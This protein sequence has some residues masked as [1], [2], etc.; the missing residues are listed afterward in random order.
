MRYIHYI[1]S[2]MMVALMS[3][4]AGKKQGASKHVSDV[5]STIVFEEAKVISV[6][7]DDDKVTKL[8]IHNPLRQQ[9]EQKQFLSRAYARF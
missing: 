7:A 3:C 6:I 1:L 4:N 9:T 5:V 8:Q 2:L